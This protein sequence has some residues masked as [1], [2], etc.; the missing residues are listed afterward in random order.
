MNRINTIVSRYNSIKNGE[1]SIS[2]TNSI[3]NYQ[4]MSALSNVQKELLKQKVIMSYNTKA[5]IF[6]HIDKTF[7]YTSLKES[8]MR[9]TKDMDIS[10]I[11]DK[12][13]ELITQKI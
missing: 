5:I 10:E 13:T 2:T 12:I 11:E 8:Y 3:K 9:N 7:D 4:F 1:D 6:P